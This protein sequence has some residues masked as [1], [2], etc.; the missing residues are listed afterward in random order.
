MVS[1]RFLAVGVRYRY[2]E[3]R[4]RG[5]DGDRDPERRVGDLVRVLYVGTGGD[6]VS[7]ALERG[8]G[9]LSVETASDPE[10]A[11]V[12]I[13]SDE[14]DCV[15]TDG[16]SGERDGGTVLDEVRRSHP[17]L[18]VVVYAGDP[19]EEFVG[20]ALSAGATDVVRRPPDTEE[21]ALLAHR[22][23]AAVESG[24]GAD[25]DDAAATEETLRE[26]ERYIRELH[27]ITSN[28]ETSFDEKVR[29]LLQMGCE[30]LDLDFGFLI[31]TDED[32]FEV[33]EMYGTHGDFRPGLT[34]PLSR[35]Y[36]KYVIGSDGVFA[37]RDAME[38]GYADDPAGE[39]GIVCY[40]GSEV[41]VGD[42]VFGTFCLA[43]TSPRDEPFTDAEVTYV[44][45]MAEWVSYG[46]ERRRAETELAE[47]VDRL[48]RSNDELERFAYVASHDL[49][50]PLRMVSSYLRLLEDRYADELDGDAEEFIAFAVDG[51]ERMRDMIQG[52][53]EYSRVDTHGGTFEPTDCEAVVDEATANLRVAIEESD[54]EL[55]VES[56]PT[57]VAD[58]TQLVQLF[59]N[60]VGNAVEHGGD[61]PPRIRVA[62]ERDDGEWAFSV[63][64]DGV[65]IDP[66]D[67]GHVF[68]MFNDLDG[69]GETGT[70]IGLAICE[71]IVERHDGRIWVESD[72]GEGATFRFTIPDRDGTVS[73]T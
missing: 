70:G 37:L 43:T 61:S 53:L 18:P 46:L 50:E 56:L 30:R 11:L 57:V 52:L 6:P 33:H 17:D 44:E 71:K 65:G 21:H 27:A 14:V 62:A 20:E 48:E 59:Q 28:A 51:A 36:C 64:D 12:R 15:V 55:T 22:I 45:L 10:S 34:A 23:D 32:E 19:C 31:E 40:L 29:R 68:E 8:H 72:P 1:K 63:I 13:E 9:G 24:G 2:M 38:E 35:T 49:Q 47:T 25:C 54:A 7:A 39:S 3:P 42:E 60:L 41:T 73:P 67:A 5:A 26:R 58:E 16:R 69:G 66:D 4:E